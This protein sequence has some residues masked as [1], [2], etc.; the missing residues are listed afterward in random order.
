MMYQTILVHIKLSH[1]NTG[2][3]NVVT[4]LADRFGSRVVGVVACQPIP[5]VY[6]DVPMPPA[7]M[8]EDH[9]EIA[10]EMALAEAEFRG[11][12]YGK[13]NALEWRTS[14]ELEPTANFVATASRC[15]DLVVTS[16]VSY[17][18]RD[19]ARREN[20]VQIVMQTGRPVLLV[21]REAQGLKLDRMTIAWKDTR[22][23]RRA[24]A[25]ALPLLKT[26]TH[27]S[28]LHLAPERDRE[29]AVASMNDVASW[30]DRHG[31][32]ADVI[33]S[34]TAQGDDAYQ[35][36]ACLENNRTDVVIAGA[37]GHSRLREWVFGG[38]TRDLTLHA[39]YSSLL[40]H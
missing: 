14:I 15:A 28:I 38:V 30:L 23:A 5:I 6:C 19:T 37:Y 27:V 13:P 40:S 25:D 16:A 1:T 18:P 12:F 20:P 36:N 17:D 24:V 3:L 8:D 35:L 7:L 21:P 11:A 29:A 26:A 33:F 2:L 39:G 9:D 4:E 31:I 22:E 34:P 32:V 10:R